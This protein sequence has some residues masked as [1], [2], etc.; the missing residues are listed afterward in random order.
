MSLRVCRDCETEFD[1]AKKS[2]RGGFIDQCSS[3]SRAS[4]DAEQ[5]Y[6]GKPGL[7]NKDASIEIFRT[8]LA[9]VRATINRENRIGFTANLP[10]SSPGAEA[11][12]E[13]FA[14]KE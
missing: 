7:T 3:C 9:R 8:D 12:K 2:Y 10:I 6:L 11:A 13:R 14:N 5:R 1:P 4:G